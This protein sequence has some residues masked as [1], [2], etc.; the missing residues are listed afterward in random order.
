MFQTPFHVRFA[1]VDKAGIFYYP[2][3][4]ESDK[5]HLLLETY[6]FFFGMVILFLAGPCR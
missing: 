2:F 1:D 5:V 6:L 3:V 4:L